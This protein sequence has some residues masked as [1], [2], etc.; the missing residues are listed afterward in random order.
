[1]KAYVT[2]LI[3]SVLAIIVWMLPNRTMVEPGEARALLLA[4]TV[5]AWVLCGLYVL[6]SKLAQQST[7]VPFAV[8]IFR[9]CCQVGAWSM[10]IISAIIA[11]VALKNL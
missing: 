9:V 11:S 3:T 4:L 10:A 5:F 2:A 7:A 8:A 1:M 6:F